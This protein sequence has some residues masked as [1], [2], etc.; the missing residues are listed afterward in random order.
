MLK[1]H[2][3]TFKILA[4]AGVLVLANAYTLDAEARSS[5]EQVKLPSVQGWKMEALRRSNSVTCSAR[6]SD[7]NGE[8]LTLLANTGGYR[9]GKWFLSA[10]S[11]DHHLSPALQEAPANLF[12]DGER[13]ITGKALAIGGRVGN[14][15]T[16][17]H[18]RF[19]FPTI[20]AYVEDIKTA[21][22]IEVQAHGLSPFGLESLSPIISAVQQCLDE[23]LNQEFWKK[24]EQVCN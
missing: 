4:F 8:I 2:M 15:I 7:E 1:S 22:K 3:P 11:R 18:V 10:I 9:G 14:R 16:Q 19:D 24:A 20:D 17:P 23:S 12:L 5:A 21:R 13:V 6:K